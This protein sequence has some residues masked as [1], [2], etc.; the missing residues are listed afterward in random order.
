MRWQRLEPSR[1][2]ARMVEAH[3][4]GI[5]AHCHE[6]FREEPSFSSATR[7]SWSPSS[8]FPLQLSGDLWGGR[9]ISADPRGGL[10][11]LP[12]DAGDGGNTGISGKPAVQPAGHGMGPPAVS[13]PFGS[14]DGHSLRVGR[15][16]EESR[17]MSGLE[18][19]L[20]SLEDSRG[21]S[22]TI[23]CDSVSEQLSS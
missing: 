3:R 11:R 6:G 14:L 10:A 15:R 13:P 1:K 18:G 17:T 16:A 23:V 9:H 19:L 21:L 22:I 7:N 20:E 2:F 5:E 4:D 8:D 12:G